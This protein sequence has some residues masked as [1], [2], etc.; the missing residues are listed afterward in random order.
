MARNDADQD[1]YDVSMDHGAPYSDPRCGRAKIQLVKNI[2]QGGSKIRAQLIG[3]DNSVQVLLGANARRRR[4]VLKVT[5]ENGVIYI[6]GDN[7][8]S[9]GQMRGYPI[10]GPVPAGV[11]GS[12]LRAEVFETHTQGEV[13]AVG[14]VE[15]IVHVAVFEEYNISEHT[16]PERM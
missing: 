7:V 13:W 15:G 9:Q 10:F 6:G 3:V 1:I 12:G 14:A 5:T 11:E 2:P 16:D 8:A 4:A